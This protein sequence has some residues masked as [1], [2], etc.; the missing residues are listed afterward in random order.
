M[1]N[2][3]RVMNSGSREI[4]VQ[5]QFCIKLQFVKFTSQWIVMPLHWMEPC[6]FPVV[7]PSAF[8]ELLQISAGLTHALI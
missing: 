1:T 5:E 8:R 2:S 3:W 6:F 7:L 4:S